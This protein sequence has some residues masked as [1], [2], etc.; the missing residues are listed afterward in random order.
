MDLNELLF[1]VREALPRAQP[2]EITRLLLSRALD[3]GEEAEVIL[4]PA[5]LAYVQNA[6]RTRIRE[7]EAE[8]FG[9]GPI[10]SRNPNDGRPAERTPPPNPAQQNMRRLL[11]EGCYVPGH[12][13][14]KWGDMTREM[15][16]LRVAYLEGLKDNLVAGINGT[17]R[18][19]QFAI[20]LLEE[21]AV[22]DL[23]GYVSR[24]GRLPGELS[25]PGDGEV[26]VA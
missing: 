11:T 1:K 9:A 5:V 14:P 18:R 15:H 22:P 7:Q 24:Y 17:I 8:V 3:F 21:S 26:P 25:P 23:N 6:E 16:G 2:H 19:H 20:G 12:G 10:A 4:F 13:Y